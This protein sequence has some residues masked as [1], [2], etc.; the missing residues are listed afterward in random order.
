MTVFRI[1]NDTIGWRFFKRAFFI[2]GACGWLLA[3]PRETSG[4]YVLPSERRIT[5]SAGLDPVGGIPNNPSIICN[6]LDPTGA[7]NNTSQ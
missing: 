4:A 6:G 3:G 1:G 7:T 2:L 5:W